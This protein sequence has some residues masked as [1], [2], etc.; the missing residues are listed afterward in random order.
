[1]T[2]CIIRWK[3]VRCKIVRQTQP[4]YA[5][6]GGNLQFISLPLWQHHGEGGGGCVDGGR[7][8]SVGRRRTLCSC[9]ALLSQGMSAVLGRATRGDYELCT[10]MVAV[11]FCPNKDSGGEGYAGI[12]PPT[13]GLQGQEKWRACRPVTSQVYTASVEE[14]WRVSIRYA[15]PKT[16]SGWGW[17]CLQA[18]S[19]ASMPAPVSMHTNGQ[20]IPSIKI[21]KKQYSCIFHNFVYFIWMSKSILTILLKENN[22]SG[23]LK[24]LHPQTL[25]SV[26]FH[27]I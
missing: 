24:K 18:G 9:Y 5:K 22:V 3:N 2:E 17:K 7:E 19:A 25:H 23:W 10:P 16:K 21:S 6:Y 12:C 15:W 4:C 1:M 14:R 27:L 11:W 26:E 8:G 13:S 20:K